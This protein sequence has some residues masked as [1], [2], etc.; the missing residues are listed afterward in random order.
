MW[1]ECCGVELTLI[2]REWQV[3]LSNRRQR[4][5]QISF[6]QIAGSYAD[7]YDMLSGFIS[8]AGELND[9]GYANPAFDALL[10]K[11]SVTVDAAAR[12]QLLGQAERLLLDDGAVIPLNFPVYRAVVNP[13]IKGW[14][15]NPLN[16]T[17]TRFLSE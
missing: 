11:S 13:R 17:P 2:N 15:E 6:D 5:F 1:K 8:T 16:L 7:P 9:A 14:A 4:D 3:F 10:A 12:S